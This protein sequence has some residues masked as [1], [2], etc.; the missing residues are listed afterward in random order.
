MDA[1]MK[2]LREAVPDLKNVEVLPTQSMIEVGAKSLDVVDVV[3]TTMRQ[4]KVKI[5]RED[6][7]KIK[8]VGALVAALHAAQAGT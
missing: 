7:V 1:L 6:L 8:T 3:S 4:L 5:A 2:N